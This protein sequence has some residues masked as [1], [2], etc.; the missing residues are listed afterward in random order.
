MLRG[1]KRDAAALGALE[2]DL[3]RSLYLFVRAQGRPVTETGSRRGHVSGTF[4][5]AIARENQ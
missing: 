2:D 4:F 5:H 3:R 1:L